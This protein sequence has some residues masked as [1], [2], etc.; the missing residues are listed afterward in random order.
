MSHENKGRLDLASIAREVAMR[1]GFV[2]DFPSYADDPPEIHPS[3]IDERHL[4]WSSVDN[5]ESTDLDQIEVAE[6]L[7]GG[8]IRVKLA[9]A[10]VDVY[11]PRGSILDRH[12]GKNTTSLY[13]GVATFPMLPDELSSGATS[14][15]AGEERLAVVTQIDVG[16]DGAIGASRVYEARVKNH[17]KLVYEDVG[18]WLEGHAGPPPEVANDPRLADQVRMQ[19]E[20]AQRLRRRRIDHGALQLETVE[21]RAI[22]KGGEVV[23]LQLTL[24]SRARE[25][26]EDLMIAANGATARWLEE[27][28]FASIRRVVRKPKR[29][30]RIVALAGEHGFKL[31]EQPDPVALSEFL[32][33]R[34][35]ADPSRFADVS[36]SVV[37]L[38]GPGEY[39]VADPDSPEGH[40]GLAVDDYAHSTAPN[41]RY[42]DLVTQRLLKAAVRGP[43]PAYT[44]AE[45]GD[46][47]ERCTERE[48]HARKFERTMRKVAAALF[49][50]HRIGATFDAVVTG[51]S[52]KGTFVRTIDPPAE[53][54]VIQ[55]EAGL[56]VGDRTRVRLVATEPTRGFIDFVRVK[57]A[58]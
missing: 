15:L 32:R 54:R 27:R 12:A 57:D 18:G 33:V 10:D 19:D 45:L 13:A 43:K 26:V 41:R 22:A 29:W 2:V 49:L 16:A 17:A 53:G 47:A 50:S 21:A 55:G 1:E 31:P 14:L 38:L 8:I 48:D 3:V 40:F 30:D 25:L 6:R 37:K 7:P 46:I 51:V 24:K 11:V 20:A 58:T 56:D 36:L 35:A 23:D 4:P 9:I 28:R 5:R 42:G 34:H 39:A 52:S 44:A